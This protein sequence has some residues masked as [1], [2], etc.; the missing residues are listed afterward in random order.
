MAIS[1]PRGDATMEEFDQKISDMK[2]GLSAL[3]ALQAGYDEVGWD[4]SDP[5]F[6]KYR[7]IAIHLSS[8]VGQVSSVCEGLDHKDARGEPINMEHCRD[9]L[10]GVV[11]NIVFHMAQLANLTNFELGDA[12]LDRY[13]ENA[14]RFA[15]DSDFAS[16]NKAR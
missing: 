3:Q 7:H 15:P 11:S 16:I 8:L 4:I 13:A 6:H 5:K 9:E 1:K 2:R 12:V 14:K 10:R